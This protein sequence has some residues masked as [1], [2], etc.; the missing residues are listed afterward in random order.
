MS[1]GLGRLQR[2]I[3]DTLDD[4]KQETVSY[5]GGYNHLALGREVLAAG[6][7]RFDEDFYRRLGIVVRDHGRKARLPEGVY[8]LAASRQ[9]LRQAAPGRVD[10]GGGATPAF[11]AAF[12]RAVRGLV[13]RGLLV[14]M[15]VV[16]VG[17]YDPDPDDPDDHE[18]RDCPDRTYYGPRQIRFVRRNPS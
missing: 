18:F 16:P 5:R 8:D 7:S 11:Q 14:P 12:S 13:Q 6:R 4:A 10:H 3:L 1:R 9:H 2:E 17:V 15:V